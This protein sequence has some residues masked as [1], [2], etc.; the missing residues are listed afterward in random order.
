MTTVTVERDGPR[1]AWT[2][3]ETGLRHYTWQGRKLP[4][5]TSIRNMA[6]QPHALVSW[7]IAK[8]CDRAVDELPTLVEMMNREP[9]PRERVLE[10]NRRKEARAWL[11]AAHEEERDKAANRGTAI[12]KAAEHG[13]TPDEVGD[14]VDTESGAVIPADELR[15]KLRQYYAWL[16]ESRADVILKERQVWNLTLGYAGSFDLLCRFP[17]GELWIVDI[18]TGSGTYSDHVLQQIAYLMAEFI[19][20]DDVVDDDATALLHQVAGVAILHL[21][22]DHWEFIRPEADPAAW[23]AFRGLLSYA[24]W[25]AAHNTPEAFTVASRTGREEAAA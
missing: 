5:V 13:V 15:A 17:N 9:R 7:K 19:G 4:S 12:H 23:S 2:D 18:K 22:D 10:K 14:Y 24:T 16:A 8:V 1:N 20:A 21:Q 6:G 3:P 11:R 25:T